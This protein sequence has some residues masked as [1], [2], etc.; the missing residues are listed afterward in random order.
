MDS[1]EIVYAQTPF[2][3][4]VHRTLFLAG[5]TDR[6]NRRTEWRAQALQI[7]KDLNFKGHVFI[8]ESEDGKWNGKGD[9]QLAW[10]TNALERADAILFWIPRDL[11]LLPGFTTNIEFG[12]W[13]TS[14]KVVLGYPT[15]GTPKMNAIEHYAE[16]NKVPVFDTLKTTIR[17]AVEHLLWK[18]AERH[19]EDVKIPLREWLAKQNVKPVYPKPDLTADCVAINNGDVLLIRRKKEPFKGKWA[20][21]GGY[22]NKGEKSRVAAAREL[23]EETGLVVDKLDYVGVYDDDG[24][25]PRGWVVSHAYRALNTSRDI[26]AGDDA[27]E[28]AWVPLPQALESDLAFDHNQILRDALALG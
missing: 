26:V 17:A 14:G 6:R 16:V 18:S 4:T 24:R 9:A 3:T 1:L 8:P 5:P 10:E 27:A 21:P 20:L 22:I 12:R 11:N 15:D 19:G 13:V 28:A 2:P 25:D 23:L 7:L